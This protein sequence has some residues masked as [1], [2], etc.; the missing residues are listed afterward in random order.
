MGVAQVSTPHG[1]IGHENTVSEFYGTFPYP[2]KPVYFDRMSDPDFHAALIRQ[3]TGRAGLGPIR[4]IWVAGCGTNQALIT[5]LQF[6]AAEV[7]GTDVSAESLAI[8]RQNAEQL[9]VTNLRLVQQGITQAGYDREFDLVVC[10]GVIH[11]NP[12]PRRCLERLSAAVRD[13][14]V[15]E[16]MVYN[17]FHRREAESFQ[18]ALRILAPESEHGHRERYALARSLAGSLQV[19]STM[20]KHLEDTRRSPEPAWADRWMNPCETSYDVDSLAGLARECGLLLEAPKVN[21]FDK[22]RRRFLWTTE[23]TDPELLAPYERL[24][25]LARWQLV[26]LLH[27][28]NSPML[29][30]YLRPDRAGTGTRVSD[31]D[32]NRMFLDGVLDRPKAVRHRHVLDRDG[33]YHPDPNASEVAAWPAWPEVKAIQE[34]ADGRRTGREIL[35]GLGYGTGFNAVQRARIM[36]TTSEFPHLTVTPAG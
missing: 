29:W 14:G 11:H 22:M 34:A 9:G 30:F 10:T 32:R 19:E 21:G 31:A 4:R 24:D 20:T 23:L 36:L 18:A 2:W 27:L 6:P 13:D 28:D 15:L 3:E 33:A 26:N 1:L 17:R 12:E 8:C 35:T 25:D 16:L 7:L 5:A